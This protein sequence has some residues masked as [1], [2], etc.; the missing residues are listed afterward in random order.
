MSQTNTKEY[1]V[2]IVQNAAAP[3][4]AS[5]TSPTPKASH[6]PEMQA[7]LDEMARLRSENDQLRTAK[8]KSAGKLSLKVSAK[9]ALSLYGLGRW[10]VTLYVEQWERL[11]AA[12]D[13]VKAFI[14]A[15]RSSLKLKGDAS[16]D[17]PAGTAQ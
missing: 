11:I 10:P 5:V 7:M 14:A 9:G 15:N 2:K 16:A 1:P 6:S 3:A 17:V 13:E 4:P 12:I 8:A